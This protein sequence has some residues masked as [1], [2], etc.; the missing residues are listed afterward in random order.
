MKTHP[1]MMHLNGHLL[2]S[3]DF[4]TTGLRAGWHEIIQVA[5]VPLNSD[6]RPHPEL[7]VFYHNVA[8][9]HPE[10]AAHGAQQVHG[11]NLEDLMLNAPSAMRVSDLLIEWFEQIDLPQ[12]KKLMPL[13]HNWEFE[14]SFGRAWLGDDLFEHL[15]HG[16]ARD[17]MRYALA[18]NDRAL[19]AS[20]KIPFPRVGL[21]ALC[22]K[23]GITN[24]KPH[25]ALH[26]A[27]AEAEV[28][29]ALIKY[30]L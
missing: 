1:G 20:E 12:A 28:Y 2:V 17:G 30:D 8:P 15:F 4:E 22:K 25:D 29:R 11:L 19:F 18:L 9:E 13:A 23:L 26:D 6:L 27:M 7:P 14:R 10:R 21:G 24:D 3:I 16:H 5:L